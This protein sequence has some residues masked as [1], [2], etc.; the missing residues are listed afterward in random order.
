MADI[1]SA[2]HVAMHVYQHPTER[3]TFFA[4]DVEPSVPATVPILDIAGMNNFDIP[5]PNVAPMAAGRLVS[6]SGS[7]PDSS[8]GYFAGDFRA[9]YAPGVLLTGSGQNVALVEFDG[10]YP[11]D[12]QAYITDAALDGLS[13]TTLT[14]VVLLDGF[15]GTPGFNNNEVALD[16]EMIMAM[17]PSVSAINVY[18]AQIARALLMMF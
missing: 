7:A 15:D 3:R 16:I 5:R 11:S 12:I 17:A 13:I 1:E 8:G 14:N 4:P 10:F 18:E 2:F 6:S 9:A